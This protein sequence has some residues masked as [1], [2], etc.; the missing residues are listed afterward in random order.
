MGCYGSKEF[1][2]QAG[3][4]DPTG[5]T[6]QHK[7]GKRVKVFSKPVWKTDEALTLEA[8][9]VSK[10][11]MHV[12][13]HV[14]FALV[15]IM[16]PSRA[17]KLLHCLERFVATIQAKREVFWDTSPHYGGARGAQECLTHVL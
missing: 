7:S 10:P 2:D 16:H 5:E 13:L 1:D 17:F 12:M 15:T 14:L 6:R 9:T 8:I 4:N 11:P 3:I